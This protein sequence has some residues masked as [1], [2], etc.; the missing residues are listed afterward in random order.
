MRIHATAPQPPF[1][2]GSR[3]IFFFTIRTTLPVFCSVSTYRRSLHH[4]VQ[5]ICAI[6]HGAVVTSLEHLRKR[7]RRRPDGRAGSGSS[8]FLTG[9]QRVP[10]ARKGFC[11]MKPR[12]VLDVRRHASPVHVDIAGTNA[13]R[14]RRRRRRMSCRPAVKSVVRVV[15]HLVGTERPHQLEVLRRADRGDVGAGMLGQLHGRSADRTGRAVDRGFACPG[16]RST[17][18]M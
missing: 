15:D 12:S 9:S 3:D 8:S 10:S 7:S 11:H 2:A 18:R 4:L 13:C 14:P 16:P 5:R 17:L 6:D 1:L